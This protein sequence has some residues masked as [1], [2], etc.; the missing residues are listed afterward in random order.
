[1]NDLITLTCTEPSWG[2][3]RIFGGILKILGRDSGD[4]QNFWVQEV[5]DA[6]FFLDAIERLKSICN[7]KL[8][9]TQVKILIFQFRKGWFYY[10]CTKLQCLLLCAVT[11]SIYVIITFTFI[12]LLL[13]TSQ[14]F[15][16]L[17]IFIIIVIIIIII[18]VII[19]IIIKINPPFSL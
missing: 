6:N 15:F 16:I 10:E 18:I 11:S 19:T 2:A 7:N 14:I 8:L 4:D 5:G 12:L 17:E 3:Q 13:I 9:R 1:M